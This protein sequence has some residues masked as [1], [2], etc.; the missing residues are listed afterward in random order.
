MLT[1]TQHFMKSLITVL[2]TVA[3]IVICL[4]YLLYWN[5]CIYIYIYILCDIYVAQLLNYGVYSYSLCIF[6]CYVLFTQNLMCDPRTVMVEQLLEI[7]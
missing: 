3:Y 5:I 1:L 7:N 2:I 6:R 4:F